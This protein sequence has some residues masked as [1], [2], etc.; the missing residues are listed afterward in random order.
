MLQALAGALFTLRD[1][2]EMISLPLHVDHKLLE[3]SVLAQLV[4]AVV[5]LVKR[6]TGEAVLRSRAQPPHRVL[7]PIHEGVGS[8]DSV[9][10][11]MKMT[12]VFAFLYS[13]LYAPFGLCGLACIGV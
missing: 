13:R 3:L 1:C 8:T 5:V 10:G 12:E 4:E 11:V 9:G 6:I 7:W 2:S